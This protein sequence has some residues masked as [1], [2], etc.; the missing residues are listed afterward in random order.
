MLFSPSGI[1]GGK[2][3]KETGSGS[4]YLCLPETPEY[5]A[6]TA[7]ETSSRAHIVSTE[8]QII[9]FTPFEGLNNQD[10]T[11]AV[12]HSNQGRNLLMIPALNTCPDAWTTEYSGYLMATRHNMQGTEYVCVDRNPETKP[13]AGYDR[14]ALLYP[15]EARCLPDGNLVCNIYHK[16][17]VLTCAVCTI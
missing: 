5:D 16:G 8:Y 2:Q 15:V 4:N 1:A 6:Y 7:D 12:C 17:A 14:G 10:V 9:D 11:C 13:E 3:F